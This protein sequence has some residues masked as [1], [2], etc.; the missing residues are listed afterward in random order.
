MSR[1]EA[2]SNKNEYYTVIDGTFRVQVPAS[3]PE[4]VQRDWETK[5]GKSGTKFERHVKALFGTIQDVQIAQGDYGKNLNIYLDENENGKVPVMSFSTNSRYGEDVLKKLPALKDEEYRFMPF[6]FEDR[7]NSEKRMRGVSIYSKDDEGNFTV[8]VAN[9]FYDGTKNA[10]GYPDPTEEDKDDWDFYFK[11][12]N[13]FLVK[14]AE[15]N[16]LSRYNEKRPSPKPIE[17]PA[18]TINPEDIPF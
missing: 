8:K 7:D 11:K 6:D 10:N 14:Y 9:Y 12:A 5:D 2:V 3:H 13:K 17:Y 4:A 16:V 1:E 15:D 18:E